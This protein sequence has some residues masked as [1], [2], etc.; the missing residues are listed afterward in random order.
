MLRGARHWQPRFLRLADSSAC[1]L[2][3][4][5]CGACR[6]DAHLVGG[7]WDTL[8]AEPSQMPHSLDLRNAEAGDRCLHDHTQRLEAARGIE[9]GH[10]F[11]LG[12]KYSTALEATFTSEAGNEEPLWMGCYGIGVSRL[13]QA[14][15]EQHHDDLGI[16]WPVSIA[17]FEVIVVPANVEE[18]AQSA[19][20]ETLYGALC[21]AGVDTLL[22]DRRERAGVKFKDA[23]L[24]GIPWRVVVGRGAA[25]GQVELVQRAGRL[26]QEIAASALLDT[27]LPQLQRLR[28]GLLE[29]PA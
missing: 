11:Q 15:V 13:A 8:L 1:A 16:C 14:A 19:L 26:S 22:D 25:S 24:I 12:R 6:S 20:A 27:L 5:V 4:F 21:D 3:R 28:L 2:Q 7:S 10:I 17:P 18:P 29:R 9:V 23:D